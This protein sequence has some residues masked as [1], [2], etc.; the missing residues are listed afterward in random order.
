M[1][2][3]FSGPHAHLA[4]A[5]L[6][7][8]DAA[9]F[10]P[11][12]V[13]SPHFPSLHARNDSSADTWDLYIDAP[14]DEYS[15]AASVVA[16]CAG[17]TTVVAL[18]CT[19]GPSVADLGDGYVAEAECG[20]DSPEQTVTYAPD[21]YYVA[22]STSVAGAGAVAIT[23]SCSLRGTTAAACTAS[24]SVSAS[25]TSTQ[26]ASATTASGAAYHRFQVP[27]TAGAEKTAEATAQCQGGTDDGDDGPGGAAP[28]LGV[29]AAAAW[30]LAAGVGAVGFLAAA[31]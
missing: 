31:A 6:S 12:A 26:T 11:R 27:V 19:A 10:G 13:D 4:G 1:A 20:S 28:G 21:L 9:Q 22:T 24:V 7:G 16:A 17:S 15:F 30:A 25:G 5:L 2:L 29:R 23:E 8:S 18:R 3:T 14:S